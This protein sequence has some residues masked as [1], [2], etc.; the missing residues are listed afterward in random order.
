MKK[1]N[2]L[3][4]I[5]TVCVC[6]LSGCNAS[7]PMSV[8]VSNTTRGANPFGKTSSV[9][10]FMQ[11]TPTEFAA[12]GIYRGSSYQKGECIKNALENA[13]QQ[14]YAKYHQIYEGM[15]SDYSSTV[16]NNRGNDIATKIER[17]GDQIVKAILNDVMIACMEFGEVQDDGMVECYVGITVPKGEVADKVAKEVNNVLT[18][19]E[20]EEI[21]FQEYNYRKQMEE[22]MKNYKEENK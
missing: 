14:V 8:P 4:A 7:R 17:A 13:K 20:K 21:G 15:I 19:G 2:F 3:V 11:D 6:F 12:T 16:G 1:M 22:R 9:P 10:C 18:D 5:A